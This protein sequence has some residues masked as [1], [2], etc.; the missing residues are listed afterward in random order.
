[1]RKVLTMR[2]VYRTE[3][4]NVD[5]IEQADKDMVAMINKYAEIGS[6]DMFCVIIRRKTLSGEY[7][8]SAL[9]TPDL[10]VEE[11][12]IKDGSIEKL[13]IQGRE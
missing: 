4:Y 11:I 12:E 1:M 3:P 2:H 6:E 5:S 10:N 13:I 7:R 9:A 8:I